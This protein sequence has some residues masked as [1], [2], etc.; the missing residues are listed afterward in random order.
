[1]SG[2]GRGRV[3]RVGAVLAA[4]GAAVLAGCEIPPTGVVDAGEPATGI[5]A[6]VWVYFV[7]NGELVPAHRG[8]GSPPGPEAVLRMLLEGPGGDEF[9][10]GLTTELPPELLAD[11]WFPRVSATGN[12]VQV[13][14]P[15]AGKLSEAAVGQLVCTLARAREL[16]LPLTEPVEV[17]VGD[18]RAEERGPLRCSAA[19]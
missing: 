15:L 12:R 9:D 6:P 16:E 18:G 3:R 11:G 2:G 10:T 7:L 5:Q 19:G 1:M 8:S 4:L 13:L 17:V 14:T